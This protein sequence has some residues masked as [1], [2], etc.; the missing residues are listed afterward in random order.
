MARTAKHRVART[1][2]TVARTRKPLS[3]RSFRK[4]LRSVV[5]LSMV[6]GLVLTVALPA[7][8]AFSTTSELTTASEAVTIEQ[9]AADN[10]Q[11]LVV[12]SDVT[13][14]GLSRS[15]YAAT[16]A[17]EVEKKK[18]A[19]AAAARVAASGSSAS[20]S[21]ASV[22]LNMVAPGSGAVR[23]PLDMSGI[24]VGRGFGADGYHQGIDLLGPQGTAEYAAAAGT[25]R[26]AGWYYGY[27]YAV[28][29]DSVINGQTVTTLYGHMVEGGVLVTPGQYV[30]AGQIIGLMGSTGSSTA[31]HLHFE[32]R[33]NGGLVDPYAWLLSNAG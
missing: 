31:N 28:V 21:S 5:T 32:V 30:E 19:E 10:A 18:A 6:G 24:T 33:L 27:G 2:T 22:D 8:A 11:S 26:V 16:T 25:V 13:T 29:L 15:S 12:A 23:W 9:V 14:T 7:Y 4:P 20:V 17:E 1:S 3:G